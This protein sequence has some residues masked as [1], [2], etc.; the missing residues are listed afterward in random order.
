MLLPD[1]AD[2]LA[3]MPLLD[4]FQEVVSKYTSD[5]DNTEPLPRHQLSEISFVLK[6]IASLTEAMKRAPPGKVDATAWDKLIG[7]FYCYYANTIT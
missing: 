4:R 3:I 2:P 1:E 6:A 7:K 5:E